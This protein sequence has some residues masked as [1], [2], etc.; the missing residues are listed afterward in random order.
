MCGRFALHSDPRTLAR[1]FGVEVPADLRPR[2]NVAPTQT[3]PIVRQDGQGRQFALA[4]WG[5]IPHWAKALETGYSTINARAETV[6][7]KPAFRSAF[8]YR[9]AIVPA[10]GYYEWR[11]VPG[12]KAKQPY[13]I[14]RRDR[15]PMAFA[16]LWER[17]R[18]PEGEDLES[19]S[20]I[21]TEANELMRPIHDRMPVILDP[22]DWDDWFTT[23]AGD[24]AMLQGLLRPFPAGALTAWPVSTQVNSPRNDVPECLE[25][26][27]DYFPPA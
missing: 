11:S 16:G 8:R 7:T 15:A 9:R 2:Y 26:L 13:F 10:D 3:I 12:S 6:A 25:T 4:R 14:A 17:W 27:Q 22:V 19:C 21:V 1:H 23:D 5:L 18:S 24:L 20:I